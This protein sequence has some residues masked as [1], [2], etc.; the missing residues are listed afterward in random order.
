M[1]MIMQGDGHVAVHQHEGLLDVNGIQQGRFDLIFTNPLFGQSISRNL[2][3]AAALGLHA[4]DQGTDADDKLLDR[5]KLGERSTKIQHI[6]LERCLNLLKPGGRM[7]IVLPDGFFNNPDEQNI[8]NWAEGRA[9]ILLIVSVPPEVFVSTGATVKTSLLFLRKFTDAE[10]KAWEKAT[11]TARTESE[12]RHESAKAA[13]IAER[14]TIK[15]TRGTTEKEREVR[16]LRLK[17]ITAA[18]RK[19]EEAIDTETRAEVKRHL[20]YEVPVAQVELAGLTATWAAC[21]N[22]LPLLAKEFAGYRVKQRLWTTPSAVRYDYVLSKDGKTVD[23]KQ[24]K[25][26]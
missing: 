25:P 8:R 19:I 15:T 10:A 4:G 18:L 26:A 1:N 23:R 12:A 7:G 13:L 11:A 9:R 22:Q 24:S 17:A 3:I 21:E 5:Y 16:K 14:E 20:D 2:T 6:F